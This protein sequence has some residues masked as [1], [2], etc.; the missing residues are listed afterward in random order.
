VDHFAAEM[1]HLSQ[2]VLNGSEPLTPGEG[3]RQDLRI[4]TAIYESARSGRRVPLAA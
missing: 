2:C 4:V 3:G 1:D